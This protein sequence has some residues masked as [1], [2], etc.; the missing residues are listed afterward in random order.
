M[1]T[2]DPQLSQNAEL[3]VWTAEKTPRPTDMPWPE[4]WQGIELELAWFRRVLSARLNHYFNDEPMLFSDF[5]APTVNHK[6]HNQDTHSK[7][8]ALNQP[9]P[10]THCYYTRLIS[11]FLLSDEQRLCLILAWVTEFA[12]DELDILQSRNAHYDNAFSEFGGLINVIQP[13]FLPTLQT[14]IFLIAGN[15]SVASLNARAHLSAQQNVFVA[16]LLVP[17]QSGVTPGQ[18]RLTLSDHARQQILFGEPLPPGYSASFPA[19]L[20]TTPYN[21]DDLVLPNNVKAQLNDIHLWSRHQQVLRET[22]QM[23]KHLPASYKMLFYGPSGTGKTLTAALIGKQLNQPVYRIDLSQI[24][25]KYIGETE[26]NLAELFQVA[27]QQAW[28]L[29]FD[30]ADAL[31]GQR[32]QVNNAN[33][34]H[35]NMQTGYL[36]QQIESCSNLVILATNLKN[37][38]D[39]AF[40]RRFQSV[41][42]F[43]L[44]DT[45]ARLTLWQRGFSAMADLRDIDLSVLAEQYPLTAAEINNVV[46]YASLMALEHYQGLINNEDIVEGIR[47]EKLKSGKFM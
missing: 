17:P 27:Q 4:H 3:A 6:A 23:D 16:Q 7:Q 46:R 9:K 25:S 12:P 11:S 19:R 21:W 22:W 45:A 38:I 5:P 1:N 40:S 20:L 39:P 29:F 44:P 26:Q 31:F 43:S 8:P 42:Q 36:L 41:I 2:D 34:R 37:H 47:R 30:E 35:A 33:D 28:I 10:D 13:G 32:T 18:H 15:D 24:V 14:A